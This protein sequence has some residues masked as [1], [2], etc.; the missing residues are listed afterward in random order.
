MKKIF[1]I[2]AIL[3]FG[4]L[5]VNAQN[6]LTGD[7]VMAILSKG[8]PYTLVF[9]KPGKKIPK[10][11]ASAQQMQVAHLINLFTL[12]R[13]GK[14]SIFGPVIKNEDLV[15]IIVFNST[16]RELIKNELKNDPYIK[17]GYLKYDLLDWFSIPGQ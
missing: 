15:G 8:K 2:T 13:Q 10:K 17:A 11:G 12:E 9:L 7:S 16:D 4:I 6:T 5:S 3:F 14:I 1:I